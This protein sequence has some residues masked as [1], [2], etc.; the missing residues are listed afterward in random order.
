[1]FIFSF[2]TI[3]PAISLDWDKNHILILNV[4]FELAVFGKSKKGHPSN[5]E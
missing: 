3:L 5:E 2:K 1:M 4:P